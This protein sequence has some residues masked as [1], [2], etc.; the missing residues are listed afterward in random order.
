[1][2]NK[3]QTL[4]VIVPCYNEEEALPFFYKEITRIAEIMNETVFELL[5][6]DDGS[7]DGTLDI[8]RKLAAVD[9]RVRYVSFS[10]NFGKEAAM[11]AGLE[12]ATGPARTASRNARRHKKRR[13]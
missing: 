12:N 7:S 1:M 9:K 2:E 3:P 6:V 4:T 11:F 10:R 13:L 5:F 8:L